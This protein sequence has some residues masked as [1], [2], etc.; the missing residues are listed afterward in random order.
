[1]SKKESDFDISKQHDFNNLMFWLRLGDFPNVIDHNLLTV[2][3]SVLQT[4]QIIPF[5]LV[6]I[7]IN[8]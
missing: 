2:F 1:M 7:S 4:T 8:Y 5:I 3:K 6:K